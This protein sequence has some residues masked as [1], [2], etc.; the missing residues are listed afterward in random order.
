MISQEKAFSKLMEPQ[1]TGN[2]THKIFL[3]DHDNMI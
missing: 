3:R 1:N 2:K